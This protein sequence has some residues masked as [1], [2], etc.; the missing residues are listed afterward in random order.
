MYFILLGATTAASLLMTN[1]LELLRYL[2][3]LCLFFTFFAVQFLPLALQLLCVFVGATKE[4][5]LKKTLS[6][7]YL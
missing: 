5:I 3:K 6:L 2:P 1:L 7:L 4:H